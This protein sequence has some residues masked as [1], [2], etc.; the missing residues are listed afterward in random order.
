M[1][2]E[3]LKLLRTEKRITQQ[4]LADLLK[5]GRPTIAGYETKGTQP[6]FDKLS[7]FSSF[8]NV[9]TDYLLGISDNRT[10]D[11][12]SIAEKNSIMN[13]QENDYQINNSE[14]IQKL[15][16]YYSRLNDENKDYIKGQMI[17]LFKE[18][19]KS[20]SAKKIEGTG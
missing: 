2:G 1:F 10:R 6:D 19:T 7:W 5:V 9:S 13:E 18:Q 16:G 17:Q 15:L 4:Q 8:F 3:R 12:S 11:R 20:N 14:D